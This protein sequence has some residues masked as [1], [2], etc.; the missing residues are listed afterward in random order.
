M[1]TDEM[2]PGQMPSEDDS[3]TKKDDGMK[4]DSD[5]KADDSGEM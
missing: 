1:V 4:D 3:D 5:E 2:T